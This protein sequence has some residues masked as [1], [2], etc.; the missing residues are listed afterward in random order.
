MADAY[1]KSKFHNGITI[2][3]FFHPQSNPLPEK[4]LENLSQADLSDFTRNAIARF[5]TR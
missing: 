1:V 5:E 3:E 4:I 2:I